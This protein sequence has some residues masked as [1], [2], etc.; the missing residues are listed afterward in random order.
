MNKRENIINYLELG[1]VKYVHNKRAKNLSIRINQQGEIRV[2]IPRYVSHR[3]AEAFLMTKKGWIIKK[4]SEFNQLADSGRKILEGD[5]IHVRG[6]TIHI[7]LQK[8]EQ[9]VENAI[10]R[11]L[12]EEAH[13]YLPQRV[14]ELAAEYDFN[15]TGV[16][17]RK[18]KSRWG[19]CTIKN[20]INLNSWL[21]MLPD[22]LVDYVIL[23]ELVHTRH[24]DHSKKFW[25]ALDLVTGGNS[26]KLRKELRNQRIMS[27]NPEY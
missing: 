2:T 7:D 11:I 12:K 6:K 21:M 16:K 4:L 5:V 17:I 15:I 1:D 22:H 10:W 24:R 3:R 9:S 20:G 18:M 26:K 25:E 14:K 13:A 19:S 8:K 27:I 23:H